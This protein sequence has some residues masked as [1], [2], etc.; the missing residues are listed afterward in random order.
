MEGPPLTVMIPLGKIEESSL[1]EQG[2]CEVTSLSH[3]D[4]A[5][6]RSATPAPQCWSTQAAWEAGSQRKG[7]ERRRGFDAI[8]T[9]AQGS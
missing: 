1:S 5:A 3:S 7:K 9:G 6:F 8:K 2:I 4:Y